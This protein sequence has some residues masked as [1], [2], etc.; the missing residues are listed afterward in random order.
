MGAKVGHVVTAATRKKISERNKGRPLSK[1]AKENLSKLMKGHPVSEET[2]RKISEAKLG[3]KPTAETIQRLRDSH[4]GK[5]QS[6]ELIAKRAE[7]NKG[8]VPWNKGIPQDEVTKQINRE[9]NTGRRLTGE[10]KQL[11][12]EQKLGVPHSEEHRKNW[13]ESRYGGFWYGAVIYLDL[14]YCEKWTPE[15]RE[16]CRAFWDYKCFE[17]GTPQGKKKLSVHHVHY[18]KK[19]C[20]DGSPHDMIPLCQSCHIKVNKNRKYWE[21]YYTDLLYSISPT[22]KCFF[23]PEE[24][25]AYCSPN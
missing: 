15:L 9:K 14:P 23:T 20:C 5:K 10:V 4:K 21:K 24:M 18:N 22:G 2:R 25:K 12:R 7:A 13:M 16:Q 19:T 17:C 1:E 3:Q 11:L 6:P 8:R